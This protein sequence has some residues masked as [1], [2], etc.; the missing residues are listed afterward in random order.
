MADQQPLLPEVLP[1]PAERP[2]PTGGRPKGSRNLKTR[3][4]ERVAQSEMVPIIQKLCQLAKEGDVLAAKVIVDRLWPRPRT[5]PL[6]VDLAP[7]R[8]PAELRAAMH[9]LLSRVASG[10]IPADDGAHLIAI[11]RDVLDSH[12]VQTFDGAPVADGGAP[13]DM[14]EELGRR[15]ARAIEEREKRQ[16]AAPA[17][18]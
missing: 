8:T 16:I 10:E 11:M 9:D 7:T 4:F 18:E 6:A 2:E 15:L 12:R 17:A 5:A 14:R 13:V 1:P 3:A